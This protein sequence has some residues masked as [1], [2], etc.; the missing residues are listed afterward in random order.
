M[1][2]ESN[3]TNKVSKLSKTNV[4]SVY[5]ETEEKS[6][7]DYSNYSASEIRDIPYAEAKN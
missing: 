7:V 6:V 2:I 3:Y 5:S 1:E 4:V